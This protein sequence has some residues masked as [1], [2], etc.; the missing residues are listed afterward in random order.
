PD[1]WACR[2]SAPHSPAAC[3]AIR[4]S[5]ARNSRW[6][7]PCRRRPAPPRS[8]EHTSELQSQS[9]LV[10]RLLLEKKN[11]YYGPGFKVECP[12]GSGKLLSLGEVANELSRRLLRIFVPAPYGDRPLFGASQKMREHPNC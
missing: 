2:R 5:R 3:R 12:T 7:R 8:E 11:D 10:C 1:R 4:R 9:N 6:R